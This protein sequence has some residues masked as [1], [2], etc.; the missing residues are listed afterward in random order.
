M[1]N[2]AQAWS[3]LVEPV[4][5]PV[6]EKSFLSGQESPTIE[7]ASA[8]FNGQEIKRVARRNSAVETT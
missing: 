4:D 2:S 5:L 3:L 8:D 7:P 1:G 6:I